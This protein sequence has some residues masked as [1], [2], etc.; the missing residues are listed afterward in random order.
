MAEEVEASVV[1]PQPLECI[2]A[3]GRIHRSVHILMRT[4]VDTFV[5]EYTETIAQQ[6]RQLESFNRTVSHELRNPLSTLGYALDLLRAQDIAGTE[7]SR[8]RVLALA[9]RSAERMRDL[10][11]AISALTRAS[12]SADAPN[13][14]RVE[15]A[16]V[17]REVA[18]QLQAMAQ[19]RGV[20]IRVGEE[21]PTL[22]LDPA[23]L[24]LIL[25]N[26][27]SNAIKYADPAKPERF[28]HV[29]RDLPGER[30]HRVRIT[31][32]DNGLGIPKP[33]LNRLFSRFHRAHAARDKELGN[34][35][36]GLGLAIVQECVRALSGE[37]LVESVEGAGTTFTL[38]LPREA[39]EPGDAARRE[40]SVG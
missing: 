20:G 4:T 32:H 6:T 40:G 3:V 1:E 37:I 38:L 23:R 2:A 19:A 16:T 35:G 25:M 11:N 22:V 24:E 28:V 14:Q 12:V 39:V 8:D 26:L 18:R 7:S 15:V 27:V 29:G 17:V 10:L 33:A 31:V 9:E 13:V 5:A 30:D 34:D 36:L 21:L